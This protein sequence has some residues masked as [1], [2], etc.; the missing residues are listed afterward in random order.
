MRKTADLKL[1]KKKNLSDDNDGDSGTE[2]RGLVSL[3]PIVFEP[4]EI[5]DDERISASI[6]SFGITDTDLADD[7]TIEETEELAPSYCPVRTVY[8]KFN[9]SSSPGEV[10]EGLK[11]QLESLEVKFDPHSSGYEIECDA[12]SLKG[13]YKF[14]VNVYSHP[15]DTN[16]SIVE[17][18]RRNGDSSLYRELY[19]KLRNKMDPYVTKTTKD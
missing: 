16:Q 17:V 1:E 12:E 15:T 4:D 7:D 3:T 10:F 9:C 13:S 2:V 11:E 8:T 6:G 19:V 18:Q 5:D 14:V